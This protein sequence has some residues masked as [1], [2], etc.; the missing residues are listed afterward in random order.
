M[1]A[2]KTSVV[3]THYH[4]SEFLYEAVESVNKQTIPL[5]YCYLLCDGGSESFDEDK[6]EGWVILRS[7]LNLGQF[8]LFNMFKNEF[9][10][11]RLFILDSDDIWLPIHVETHLKYNSDII[12]SSNRL[13]SN[14]LVGRRG[15]LFAYWSRNNTHTL[16]NRNW[17]GPISQVSFDLP[18]WKAGLPIPSELETNKDWYFY[19]SLTK[20]KR[21]SIKK[22]NRVTVL[23]RV[24][25]G[26]V[27][28]NLEKLRRGRELFW[29]LTRSSNQVSKRDYFEFYR[30]CLTRNLLKDIPWKEIK[31]NTGKRHQI[32]LK[33][34]I[35]LRRR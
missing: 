22:V 30:L 23:Y 25:S 1:C 3:I 10:G 15:G 18:L 35:W 33:L 14:G 29:K 16:L 9:K 4:N 21:P 27:S 20:E 34:L 12:S 32:I 19:I 6:L 11:S 28:S 7:T 17:I 31:R 24:W 8:G 5:D 2:P 26:G 13:I